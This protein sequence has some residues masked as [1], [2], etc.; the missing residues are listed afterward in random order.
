MTREY[1]RPRLVISRCIEFGPCRYDGSKIPSPT[2]A[3][4]RN[5]A[6]FIPVCPEVEIGLGVPRATLRIVRR[7]DADR[8]VQPATGRDVTEE[9]SAFVARFLDSLPPIDGFILKGGSPTS[10][11]RNVR[12]YPSME[13]SAAIAKSAGFFAREV[14][15]RYPDLPV[16]DEL[17]LNN[18]RIRDHFF[19]AIFTLA[20]FREIEAAGDREAL[21]RFHANNKLLLLASNEKMLR[22]AGRLVATRAE[23]GPGELFPR[24]RRMLSAALARAPR[25]TGNVNVLQHALG[26]FSDRISDEERA[27]CIRLID[28]YK[29][30]HATLA[31]PRNLLRS[32]VIRFREPYLTN[33]SFF[34]PYPAELVDLPGEVTD[35]GRD[36]WSGREEPPS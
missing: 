18:A 32:W 22:E 1:P 33:Q 7:D 17:R 29:N 25:Y 6:D 11:T 21:V 31:E 35:R 15:K 5:Y 12:V 28:R 19:S 36:V 34:A 3:R 4:L 16:E 23:V 26:Y 24:Y 8:L 20:A 9:M 27:Y 10:G 30:G 13:K 2:V 14:L